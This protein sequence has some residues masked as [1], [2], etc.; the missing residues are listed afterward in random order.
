VHGCHP[1]CKKCVRYTL[2]A[3][4]DDGIQK[5]QGGGRG[6]V[7]TYRCADMFTN[8]CERCCT[9]APAAAFLHGEVF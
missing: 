1:E 5:P 6:P 2:T 4:D 8:F 7:R 9:P 3:A